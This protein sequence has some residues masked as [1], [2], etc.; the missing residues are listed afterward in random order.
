MSAPGNSP[1][2][3]GTGRAAKVVKPVKPARSAYGGKY[4]H[5][6]RK[7]PGRGSVGCRQQGTHTGRQP[8]LRRSRRQ[9]PDH[10]P[11][12][13]PRQEAPGSSVGVDEG[14]VRPSD[15]PQAGGG[16]R[17]RT[18]S[19][20]R[21][22]RDRGARAPARQHPALFPVRR[23]AVSGLRHLLRARRNRH[24]PGLRV[25]LGR[26]RGRRRLSPV[27]GLR[28]RGLRRRLSP[29]DRRQ[30]AAGRPLEGDRLPGLEPRLHPLLDRQ[31][32]AARQPADPVRTSSRPAR[33]SAR[34][35]STRHR[36]W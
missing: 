25:D 21:V 5:R 34:R 3:A 9:F 12:L 11:L 16:P 23:A 19:R 22:G 14:R 27:A 4:R 13:R 29:P 24:G 32:A 2:G 30:V 17:H 10:G 7:C 15:D 31:G 28:G 33:T 1:V 26:G 36:T 35:S 18:G 8:L 20:P 6:H